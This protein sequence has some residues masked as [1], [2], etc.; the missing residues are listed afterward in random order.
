M[1]NLD[2]IFLTTIVSVLFIIFGVV[3][4]KEFR[5]ME[6]EEW[7]QKNLGNERGPRADFLNFVGKILS[8]NVKQNEELKEVYKTMQRTISDMETDGMYFPADIKEKINERIKELNCEY[9]GLPS[10]ASYSN[11]SDEK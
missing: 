10:V 6:T 5:K 8:E 7:R 3:V 1:E 4:Y 9:S 11:D 2:I